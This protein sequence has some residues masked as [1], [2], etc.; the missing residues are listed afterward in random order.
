MRKA[1]IWLSKIILI[2]AGLS[3]FFSCAEDAA[4]KTA[5]SQA[6]VSS[7]TVA[8][9]R[10]VFA[11]SDSFSSN[12][13]YAVYSD[14]RK[15]SLSASL[16]S[17][18]ID[19][20]S[21][22]TGTALSSLAEG[23]YAVKVTYSGFSTAYKITVSSYTAP[24][25]L[26]NYVSIS[27]WAN[28]SKW[29]LAN[30][31]DPTVFKWTDGYYYMFG[32]D[33]SYG[34]AHDS[35]TSGGH[36]F[37]GK[38]SKNL[39]DWEWVPGIMDEAPDWVV[40][41][42][43]EYRSAQGL[44]SISKSEI[45]FGFWAPTARKITVDGV[46]KVRLYYSI[47]VDNYIKTGA[48]TSTVFDGSWTERAFI[49]C[50]ETINPNG[51]ES[52]WTDLGFVVCSSSDRGKDG[53]SR[54][55]TNDWDAYFYFNA[56]DPSY[57]ID[58]DDSHWL[59]YGSWHSGFALVRINPSTGK[60]AAVDGDDYLT[61]NVT[62]DFEMGEPWS[63]NGTKDGPVPS[64]LISQ[65]YGTRIFSRGTSRWQPSEGPE[66]IKENGYYY[67]FFA[68]D[69]LDIPYQ[70][71]VVRSTKI[72][73]PYYAI[74]GSE[75]T[76]DVDGKKNG[77]TNIFPIVTHPYKFSDEESGSGYGSCYGWVGISHCAIF[78]DGDGNYFYMSQQRLPAN[79][80]G[81]AYSNA[82]MLGGV[83]KIV[84]SPS[85]SNGTDLWPMVLPER[86]A[87]IPDDYA[88]SISEEDLY[89]QWQHIN[90][91]YSYGNM[92]EAS[93]LTLY[94]DKTMSGAL[95][96]TWSFDE[97][98]QLLTFVPSKGS[99][100]SVKV[101]REVNWEAFPREPTLVYAGTHKSLSKTYWGKQ[102]SNIVD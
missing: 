27:G 41:K 98:N 91:A 81:N 45:S 78:D 86:Y 37:Q 16:C 95:S 67:L 84:W 85:V 73:G 32:T 7:I 88:D 11:S 79:V 87:A 50:A 5:G 68:N 9:S 38:R 21:Y 28:K 31:H 60:V 65:G 97:K 62:G 90:L 53:Y 93:G 1:T 12:G 14:G 99:S 100:V 64:E 66:L 2:G 69:A 4:E 13:V 72:Q 24:T 59:V 58:D 102:V 44:S 6:T 26:D 19:G 10:T 75:M 48:K 94:S 42:L 3:L 8:G 15:K 96:G 92:D 52:S 55:S 47:V 80:A 77:S 30:T 43:N 71:R 63:P 18:S 56:I 101:C 82:I 70:T 23:E 29:N 22:K 57:F 25:Y 17:F 46:T 49:G 61:G 40:E 74:D 33:A 51:G 34:N 35:Y 39:V 83:R 20:A 89:G 36:H 76:N 54:S